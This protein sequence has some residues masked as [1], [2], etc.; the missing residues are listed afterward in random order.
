MSIAGPIVDGPLERAPRD[1]DKAMSRH[2]VDDLLGLDHRAASLGGSLLEQNADVVE[3]AVFGQRS[4]V[5]LV[6][7]GNLLGFEPATRLEI[8]KMA[9]ESTPDTW[10]RWERGEIYSKALR[11][12]SP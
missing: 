11:T 1:V 4:V 9:L 6:G 2:P 3:V 12:N 10:S 8:A 5:A 7:E